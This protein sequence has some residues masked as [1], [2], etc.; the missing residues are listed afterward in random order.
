MTLD[1]QKIR[2]D[3]PILE[4]E[5]IYLDSAATSFTPE[6]VLQ[7]ML[8]YYHHYR[9]NIERGIYAISQRASEEYEEVHRKV[10]AFLNAKSESEIVIVRNTTEGLTTVAEGLK[11]ER[12]DKI[13]TSLLEHHSNLLPWLRIK[14]RYGVNVEFLRPRADGVIEQDELE[15]KIDD[16]TKLVALTHISNVLGNILPVGKVSKIA[17][18]HDALF[19]L[20]GAQ[21]IP[22][23]KVNVD[24][25]GC[26]FLAFSGHKM[27]GPTGVG[28]LYIR[29]DIQEKVEPLFVGGGSILEV[30]LNRYQLEKGASRF[31]A[32]TPPIAEALGLGA[33]VDYLNALGMDEVA[34]HERRLGEM[35]YRG[36]LEVP[37]VEVYGPE[38]KSK[39]GVTSFNVS[40]LNPHDVALVLDTAANIAVRSGHHCAQPL[41]KEVLKRPEGTVRASTYIYNTPEEIER[42]ISTISEIASSFTQPKEKPIDAEHP[43]KRRR[44]I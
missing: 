17:H 28:A 42:L 1:V 23:M 7:K 12:G 38:P 26:D 15:R 8:E 31:E 11:W 27:C 13:V 22:H 2:R 44:E 32:G 24:R 30:D 43:K 29:E 14:Q 33:A 19:L 37:S 20:D 40:G 10:A 5:I 36:L 9:A 21:S 39:A 18:D 35:I 16:H 41:M 25:I 3:F 6:P 34:S 4:S